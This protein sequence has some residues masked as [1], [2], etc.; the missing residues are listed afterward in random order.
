MIPGTMCDPVLKITIFKF[1]S[2]LYFCL[3]IFP[4]VNIARLP[5]CCFSTTNTLIAALIEVAASQTLCLLT[6]VPLKKD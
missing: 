1:V 3:N 2:R 6:L 5:I 4:Y